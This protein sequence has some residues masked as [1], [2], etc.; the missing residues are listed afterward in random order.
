MTAAEDRTTGR[1]DQESE[2]RESQAQ[3]SIARSGDLHSASVPT[4]RTEPEELDDELTRDLEVAAD[5]DVTGGD[6]AYRGRYQLV[7]ADAQFNP[8]PTKTP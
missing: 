2:S 5:D 4:S 1:K 7:L 3:H 8:P 6:G